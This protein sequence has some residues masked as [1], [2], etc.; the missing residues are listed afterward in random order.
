MLGPGSEFANILCE[1]YSSMNK[2]YSPLP[3]P[4]YIRLLDII[5]CVGWLSRELLCTFG[6]VPSNDDLPDYTAVSYCW[7]DQ[8]EITRLEFSDGRSLP[9]SH[10]LSDLFSPPWL[11]ESDETSRAAFRVMKSRDRDPAGLKTAFLLLGRLRFRR[12]WAIQETAVGRNGPVACGDDRIWFNQFSDCVFG[13]HRRHEEVRCETLLQMAFHCEATDRRDMVFASRAFA[14]S[15]PVT[16]PNDTVL[17][18]EVYVATARTLLC[19]GESLDLLALCGIGGGERS[20]SSLTW[21]SDLRHRSYAEPPVLCYRAG[22]DVDGL[23]REL[24][25]IERDSGQWSPP[26][27]R[28]GC[29]RQMT[30]REEAWM[31][32]LVT[33]LL[34]GVGIDDLPLDER[35]TLRYY[36]YY[37]EWFE[38][39]HS[40]LWRENLGKIAHNEYRRTMG[41][42]MDD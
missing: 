35:A 40:S 17:E 4:D 37:R 13:E 11:G 29:D 5:A 2:P 14:D 21:A 42:R 33:T 16:Q 19:H 31:D 8:A 12:V 39:L 15:P 27:G 7:G 10:T 41:L 36:A 34:F 38:R 18:E 23:L 3:G 32:R 25:R 24:P 20:P 30:S 6:V 22:W 1:N 26:S 9:L 28:R